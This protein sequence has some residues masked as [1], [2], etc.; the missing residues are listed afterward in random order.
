MTNFSLSAD[1]LTHLYGN[2]PGMA[3]MQLQRYQSLLEKHQQ[4][5]PAAGQLYLISAP[6]RT[7][8]SGNHTDHNHGKVLAAAVNLDTLA[9]VSPRADD[10]VIV[11]SEGYSPISLKLDHFS[12]VESEAGSTAALV[13]GVAT[14]MKELGYKLGGFEA[15]VTS[16][17]RSGSGLSSS[18]AFEVLLCAIFDNLYN[19]GDMPF[20]LRAQISQYTENV[21]FGKPCGLMDQM[22]SSAGG[23]VYIDFANADPEVRALSYDFAAKG[24]SLVVVNT[25]GSHDDLTDDYAAIP[26]EMK[27]VA[28]AMGKEYLREITPEDFFAALPSLREKLTIANKERALLRAAHFYHENQRV[29]KQFSALQQDDLPTFLRLVIESGRSSFCY[30][31]NIFASSAHQELAL[32]LMLSEQLL[33]GKG[34]WRVHGGGFAG[35]TLNFV[36]TDLLPEFLSRMEAVFGQ[37]SCNI[38]DVRPMGPHAVRV[39]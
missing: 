20:K 33:S 19:A 26:A 15:T 28:A 13:R 23:L 39:K 14:R 32:A 2:Q 4:S 31:Q 17:V 34:A 27:A 35:T 21:Y 3:E 7:E 30:L 18:A 8:I 9:V 11:H 36:P 6:G 25:G 12:P 37:G 24:F 1:Q 22:A 16:T 38:L 5:F 29:D 10:T